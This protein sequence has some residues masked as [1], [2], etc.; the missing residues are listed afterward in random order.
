MFV[1]CPE[2]DL[3]AAFLAITVAVRDAAQ[4]RTTTLFGDG[5]PK[6]RKLAL[7]ICPLQLPTSRRYIGAKTAAHPQA[8]LPVWW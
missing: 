7:M 8:S 6:S 5:W 2:V 4:V 3:G 1:S